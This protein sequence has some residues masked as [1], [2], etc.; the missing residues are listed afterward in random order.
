MP[1][2]GTCLVHI[3]IIIHLEAALKDLSNLSKF[4]HLV[5][6]RTMIWTHFY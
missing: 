6:I 2:T 3:I 1:S 5:N 4:A